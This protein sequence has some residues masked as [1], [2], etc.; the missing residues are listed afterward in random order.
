MLS[1]LAKG[2]QHDLATLGAVLDCVGYERDLF[3]SRV[4]REFLRPGRRVLMLLAPTAGVTVPCV[5]TI[6]G[7]YDCRDEGGDL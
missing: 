3:D 7:A 6:G 2:V 5:P 4:H 1:E